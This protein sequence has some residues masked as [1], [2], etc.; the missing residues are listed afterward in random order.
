M[1][2][3][4]LF[5]NKIFTYYYYFFEFFKFFLKKKKPFNRLNHGFLLMKLNRTVKP[6]NRGS[7][8][9]RTV[10]DCYSLKLKLVSV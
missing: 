5:R 3:K 2:M 9:N 1:K 4:G 6:L 8:R 7:V 10:A